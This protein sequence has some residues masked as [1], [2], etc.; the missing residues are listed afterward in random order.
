MEEPS[1][2]PIDDP[3]IAVDLLNELAAQTSTAIM[4]DSGGVAV[5]RHA[6]VERL[7][8]DPRLAGM[9]LTV[10]DLMG[11]DD[12]PLRRWYGSLMF[13]NEGPSHHR[14]RRLVSRAFTP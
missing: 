10:F 7:A 13:T 9:G 14:L 5:L 2:S 8:H 12:G 3:R 11:I 4:T 6:D 1:F